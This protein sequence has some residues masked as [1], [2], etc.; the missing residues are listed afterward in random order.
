MRVSA[1]ASDAETAAVGDR[2]LRRTGAC[3]RGASASSLSCCWR[4]LPS[5]AAGARRVRAGWAWP[6]RVVSGVVAALV[7]CA[8]ARACSRTPPPTRGLATWLHPL[9][10]WLAATAGAGAIAALAAAAIL[11]PLALLPWLWATSP[12]APPAPLAR[13][14]PRGFSAPPCGCARSSPSPSA[15]RCSPS[16][17]PCS[18]SRRRTRAAARRSPGRASCCGSPG[19]PPAPR[20]RRE[21]ARRRHASAP[22]RRPARG[23]RRARLRRRRRPL[24]V[25]VGRCN[26][27][28]ALCDRRLDEVSLVGTHNSMSAAGE[29]GWLFAAQ[30]ARS[31]AAR[32]RRARAADR[33]ALRLRDAARRRHRPRRTTPRAGRR[34]RARSAPR[35]V[36]T[37]RAAAHADRLHRRRH[38]RDLPLPRVLRGRR[39]ARASRRSTRSTASS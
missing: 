2:R 12:A 31:S 34:S 27:S 38:A 23:A 14:P 22:S 15:S 32:G 28:A 1:A 8:A 29:P 19:D 10:A 35:F 5:G 6:S 33:H 26:G 18:S 36:E 17:S 37:A 7:V 21:S 13:P 16:R 25:L 4:G 9:A 3:D 30:D 39:D 20:L 11:R 24:A